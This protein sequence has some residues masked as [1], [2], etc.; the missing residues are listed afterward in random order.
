MD[1][2]FCI[3]K[4]E[5][6]NVVEDRPKSYIKS[7]NNFPIQRYI[8]NSYAVCSY[9]LAHVCMHEGFSKMPNFIHTV[10][11]EN[12]LCVSIEIVRLHP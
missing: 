6:W 4:Q 11:G 7:H 8:M 3:S 9:I 1:N 5:T 10:G 2:Q 12:R